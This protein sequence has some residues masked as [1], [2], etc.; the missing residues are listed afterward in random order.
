MPAPSP[1]TKPSRLASKG[2]IAFVGSSLR[3]DMAF[4]EQKP[5]IVS[6]MMMASGASGD[7]DV[8]VRALDV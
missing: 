1:A 2:R 4:I 7:H 3:V 5:A 6:G 8:G